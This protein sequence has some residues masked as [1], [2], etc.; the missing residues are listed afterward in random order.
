MTVLIVFIVLIICINCI[1]LL[2]KTNFPK[3]EKQ[4]VRAL[5]ASTILFLVFLFL[6]FIGFKL[7][8]LYT[9]PLI[10]LTFIILTLLYFALFK[11]SKK[12]IM[13]IFLLTPLIVLGVFTQ[14]FGRT[15]KEFSINDNNK[16][17]VKTGG[18][19]SC[20]ELITIT[21][22]KFGIFDKEIYH[23]S[24][25]CLQGISQIETIKFDKYNAVFLIYHN[26]KM[27]SENPYKYEIDNKNVW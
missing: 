22:T 17:A 1:P 2:T 7:K 12:K 4:I 5:V 14:L 23:E 20:G 3:M 10:G 6:E 26:G 16:I 13:A 27:D 21:E 15:E 19:M 25:L 11:N 24:S 8:G 9:F 18:I